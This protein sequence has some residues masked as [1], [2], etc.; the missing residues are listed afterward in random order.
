M[1]AIRINNS[2]RSTLR[3]YQQQWYA[4]EK[5]IRRP[6][7]IRVPEA[8]FDRAEIYARVYGID[9]REFLIPANVHMF[10]FPCATESYMYKGAVVAFYTPKIKK[11]NPRIIAPKV[12]TAVVSAESRTQGIERIREI[13]KGL[14]LEKR[15]AQR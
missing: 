1:K 3:G 10:G 5:A 13:A 7:L 12:M 14:G 9:L 6:E 2:P 4:H 15:V 11:G 8:S